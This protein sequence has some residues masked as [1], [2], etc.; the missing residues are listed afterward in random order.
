[1]LP[2]FRDRSLSLKYVTL[3]IGLFGYQK[4]GTR[5][6]TA[7]GNCAI[8]GAQVI[9]MIISLELEAQTIHDSINK[10]LWD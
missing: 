8:T 9:G 6:P 5:L 3:W 7:T 1:M 4:Q 10:L 2:A